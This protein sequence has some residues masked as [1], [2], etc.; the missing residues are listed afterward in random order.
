MVV[1]A[2][3][4]EA[5]AETRGEGEVV[6]VAASDAV[7]GALPVPPPLLAVGANGESEG[8]PLHVAPSG[9]L[10]RVAGA[11]PAGLAVALPRGEAEA[12][13]DAV[14]SGGVGVPCPEGEGKA[15]VGV[16][17]SDALLAALEQAESEP[18]PPPL[19]DVAV[20]GAVALPHG[21]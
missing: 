13:T 17:I 9:P 8:A 10:L 21:E 5:Q 3:E 12:A 4:G 20:A 19:P 1:A 16:L 2:N 6:G 14:R 15:T 18:P 7:G 11:V